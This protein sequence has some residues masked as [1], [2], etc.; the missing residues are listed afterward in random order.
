VLGRHTRNLAVLVALTAVALLGAAPADAEGTGAITGT[1]TDAAT[2]L[3]VA[4][5]SVCAPAPAPP[6]ESEEEEG[7]GEVAPPAC[8]TTGP[9]GEYTI[10][11]LAPGSYFV[12]FDYPLLQKSGTPQPNYIPQAYEGAYTEATAKQVAVS[13]GATVSGIDAALLVGG[14]IAGRVTDATSGAP[15][16]NAAVCALRK[17]AEALGDVAC[18]TTSAGG[19]YTISGLAGGSFTVV[20]FAEGH[21]AQA[22]NGAQRESEATLVAVTPGLLVGGISAA[23]SPAPPQPPEPTPQGEHP[24]GA[25]AGSGAGPKGGSLG[26]RPTLSLRSGRVAVSRGA[27]H[28][29][30]SCNSTSRCRGR[31]ALTV[32][33]AVGRRHHRS[34][35]LVLLGAARFSIA[36]RREATVAV[37]LDRIGRMLLQASHGSLAVHLS[38]RVLHPAPVRTQALLVHLGRTPLPSSRTRHTSR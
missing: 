25:G 4:G 30:L 14:Q 20:F 38:V 2:H 21:V 35:R 34:P 31:L 8:A 17:P 22:Y 26:S 10:G 6:V 13:A 36:P 27:A 9:S 11:A 28:L 33:I 24:G 7:A 1:V 15:L 29:V 23:L 37:V 18:A 3:P 12:V 19:E 32:R 5:I 16:A